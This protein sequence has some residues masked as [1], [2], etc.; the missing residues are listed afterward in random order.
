[1][2]SRRDL[3]TLM[4]AA[5]GGALEFYDFIIFVFFTTI[6]AQLFFPPDMPEW[7]PALGAPKR[8]PGGTRPAAYNAKPPSPVAAQPPP[9]RAADM[10][11][12]A[13]GV[14]FPRVENAAR[15]ARGLAQPTGPS[16]QKVPSALARKFGV[17][18]FEGMAEMS[19]AVVEDGP[20][21]LRKAYAGAES[22]LSSIQEVLTSSVSGLPAE[23]E[24]ALTAAVVSGNKE[25]I[26]SQDFL[27]KQQ[28]P[29]YARQQERALKKLAEQEP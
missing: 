11:L 12:N 25:A 20:R 9:S 15:F 1:M 26:R 19:G 7:L 29:A 17:A 3:R 14:L 24:K 22:L 28:H 6:I 18:G 16:A 13:T 21:I 4:L 27:L 23:A 10:A 8:T 2:L 5:L